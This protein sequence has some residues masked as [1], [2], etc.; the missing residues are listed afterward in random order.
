VRRAS[1]ALLAA[2]ATA[3]FLAGRASAHAGLTAPAAT[4]YLAR[5]SSVPAGI[6][7]KVV[8]GDQRLWLRV[9]PGFVAVVLGLRGEPYLRF[10]S[11]GVEVNTRAPTYYLNRARPLL[12][13]PG[14]TRSTPPVWKEITVG[15]STSW[16]EDRLH[17]LALAAHPAGNSFAGRWLV[18]VLMNG[19]RTAITGGLWH[20]ASP[21]LLWFWPLLLVLA[22]IPAL[23]RLG[24]ARLDAVAT[25]GLAALALAAA[26]AARLGR[27]LYGRPTVSTWQ[28]VLAGATCAVAVALMA[29]FVRREWRAVAAGAIGVLAV[30][31]GLALLGVLRNGFVLA[32]IP[33]WAERMSAIVSLAAGAALLVVVVVA[34]SRAAE[35]RSEVAVSR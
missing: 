9:G 16:H 13:P 17:A 28:L 21:S 26:T 14:L 30:Y 35:P 33:A 25:A 23:L 20:A 34:P 15:P 24:D 31:Q 12:V 4:S 10:S 2:L 11:R 1:L 6:E 5:I 8:D 22:C 19:K 18:P 27:E 29:L 32:A 3:G 7:A